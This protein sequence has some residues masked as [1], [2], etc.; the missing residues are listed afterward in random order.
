MLEEGTP[1]NHLE[2]LTHMLG[3]TGILLAVLLLMLWGA[4]WLQKRRWQN[5]G[6][7]NLLSRRESLAISPKTTLHVIDC[8][9]KRILVAESSEDVCLLG[10]MSA[11]KLDAIKTGSA[12]ALTDVDA[13]TARAPN[14]SPHS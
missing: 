8:G 10:E 6:A 2:Q 1:V 7:V 11:F 4:R 14:S 13:S 9:A 5:T 12:S 3:V